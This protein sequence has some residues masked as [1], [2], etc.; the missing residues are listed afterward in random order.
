MLG[1]RVYLVLMR[2]RYAIALNADGS[3]N[4][5]R[6][7]PAKSIKRLSVESFEREGS[8]ARSATIHLKA[9][10]NASRLNCPAHST[11]SVGLRAKLPLRVNVKGNERWV[12]PYR[13]LELTT[14]LSR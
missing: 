9:T 14:R 1:L 4:S 6:D 7:S 12:A 2:S 10:G 11:I 8:T 3:L 13:L 5:P